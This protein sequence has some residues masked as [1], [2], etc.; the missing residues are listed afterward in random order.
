MQSCLNAIVLQLQAFNED[1]CQVA[2][3]VIRNLS[4]K[5][6]QASKRHLRVSS[7]TTKLMIT[8]IQVVSFTSSH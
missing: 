8:A 7:A 1:L 6:D 2:A 5:A 3:S 4:W